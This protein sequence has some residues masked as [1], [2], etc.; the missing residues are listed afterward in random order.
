MSTGPGKRRSH[1]LLTISTSYRPATDLGYLLYKNPARVQSFELSFG[2]V[3]VF[4]PEASEERCTVAL[5]LDVDPVGLVRGKRAADARLEQYVNDRPYVAS[6]FLSVAIAQVFGTA[7][8]GKSRERPELADSTI[9]LEAR[10]A[11]LPSR[12]GSDLL[13]RL[14]EPLGYE[15]E[16][17]SHVLDPNFPAWGSSSY[18]TVTLRA[19]TRLVDLLRHLYVLVP[20][21]DDT[22]HYYVG[23]DEVE[24]L[25]A[26]G[27]QWLAAHPER[28]LIVRR[29]LRHRSSLTRAALARLTFEEEPDVDAR[30]ETSAAEEEA[31]E[32]RIGLNEQRLNAVTAVLRA[33]GARRVVDLGCGE[34]KLLKMLLRDRDFEEI[35]GVD[36]SVRSLEI[37]QQ[38]LRLD[39]LPAKQ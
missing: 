28:E 17:L 32:T 14:F 36:V 4:Y 24:K 10:I 8:S 29:Y 21:L 3:H 20:V 15:V 26:K 19:T 1:M 35:L 11:V 12:R 38:R 2:R 16:V 37:A 22:K 5:L 9:P 27:E 13:Q 34:G 6:S 33:N 7:L 18:F 30:A 39:T 23:A 25:L 31:V